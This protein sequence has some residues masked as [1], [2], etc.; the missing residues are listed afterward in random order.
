MSRAISAITLLVDDYDPAIRFFVDAL[1]FTLVEDTPLGGGKRWVLVAPGA[2]GVPLLLAQ[3]STPEQRARVGDQTGGRVALFLETDDFDR[4]HARM[5]ARG[6]RFAEAPR[7]ETYG[8][9]AVFLD[10]AGNR[11]DLLQRR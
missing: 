11:W 1:D 3:A 8:T 6:V 2:G 10:L 5:R 4:D 9:V 7:Q